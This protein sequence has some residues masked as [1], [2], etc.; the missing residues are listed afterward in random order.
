MTG[1]SNSSGGRNSETTSAQI[2][3]VVNQEK[4]RPIKTSCSATNAADPPRNFT[5]NGPPLSRAFR[6]W[7]STVSSWLEITGLSSI[8]SITLNTPKQS[9]TLLRLKTIPSGV[10][11]SG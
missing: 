11:V 5:V 1:I 4:S 7:K 3:L 9:L 6:V 10:N 2:T 8:A